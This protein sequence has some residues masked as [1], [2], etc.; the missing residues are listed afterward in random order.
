MLQIIE[1]RASLQAMV[2]QGMALS[3]RT[4]VYLDKM[5]CIPDV[6]LKE[7]HK[8]EEVIVLVE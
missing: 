2:G 4:T 5:F 7:D 3:C 8:D 1:L 6:F